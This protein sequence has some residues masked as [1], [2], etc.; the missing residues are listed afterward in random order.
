[1]SE[2]AAQICTMTA[3]DTAQPTLAG[4]PHA[5]AQVTSVS[6][7]LHVAGPTALGGHHP[8]SDRG[9]L[10]ANGRVWVT[11]RKDDVINSGGELIEPT[12][13]E[14]VLRRHPAIRDAL[15]FGLPDS[16]WGERLVALVI[17]TEMGSLPDSNSL[18]EWCRTET[19]PV[20]APQ[21]FRWTRTLPLNAL[22]KVQRDHAQ[23]LWDEATGQG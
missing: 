11:G 13:V 12:G 19:G 5:F 14:S 17:P 10:D 15:V 2:T 8:T 1:M 6:G 9:S 7:V 20:Q 3:E 18:R 16:R 23:A 4:P 22:G 21:A